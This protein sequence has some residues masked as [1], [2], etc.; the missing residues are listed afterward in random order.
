MITPANYACPHPIHKT[1]SWA[2][3]GTIEGKLHNID[4][5][6]NSLYRPEVMVKAHQ[7]DR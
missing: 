3:A 4:H 2:A 6:K 1:R 5:H 7:Q